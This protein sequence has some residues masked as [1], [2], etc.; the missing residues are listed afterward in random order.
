[1]L[2]LPFLTPEQHVTFAFCQS[3]ERLTFKQLIAQFMMG[4]STYVK[5][6]F[7]YSVSERINRLS[8]LLK[9]IIALQPKYHRFYSLLK[10]SD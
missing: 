4:S 1:M 5:L 3:H 10:I 2:V 7:I 9:I 6:A 8:N